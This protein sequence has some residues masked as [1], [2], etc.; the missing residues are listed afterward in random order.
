MKNWFLTYPHISRLI[1]SAFLLAAAL[2]GSG[3]IHIPFVPVG[4]LLVILITWLMLRS[5]GRNLSFLG[6]DVKLSHLVLIPAGLLLGITSFLL[7]FY[8][9]TLVRG[10]HIMVSRM[11]DGTLLLKEFWRV[12]PTAA[13]QDFIIV[14]YCYVKL[15]EL[16]N[17]RNATVMFGL[18]F[19]CL[20]DIWGDNI[21]ND[22]FYASGLFIGYLMFSTALLRS[23]SIWLVIGLHWGNNFANSYLFTFTH[24]TTSWLFISGQQQHNLT[25]WQAIGLFIALNIGTVSVI[26]A[27][28]L[29]WRPKN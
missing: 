15:I 22:L 25:V 27:I 9:G 18:F 17:K 14:G 8:V 4:M 12:L 24:T 29:I 3:F 10:D 2:I 6:F 1:L 19:I 5:E 23:G 7:S 20:H 21:V 13:V 28:K 26:A 11:I 16:T